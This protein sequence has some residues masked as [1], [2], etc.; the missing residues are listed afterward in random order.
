MAFEKEN[1]A[2]SSLPPSPSSPSSVVSLAQHV[3]AIRAHVDALARVSP[4][5]LDGAGA[6]ALFDGVFELSDRM[7]AIAVRALPV[8]EAGRGGSV[9][10]R[11]RSSP[12][13]QRPARYAARH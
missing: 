7:Q 8:V 4:R 1:W 9:W 5:E 2:S 13:P 10:S 11:P 3:A 12:P 6:L